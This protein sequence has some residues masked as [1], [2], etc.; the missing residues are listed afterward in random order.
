MAPECEMLDRCGFFR[1]YLS[2]DSLGCNWFLQQYCR[3]SRINECRRKQ[4][5]DKYGGPPSDDMMPTGSHV[6][7]QDEACVSRKGML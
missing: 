4:Y 3:G 5:F 2:T 7:Q 1:K 6:R